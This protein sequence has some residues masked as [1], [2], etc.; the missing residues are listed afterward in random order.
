[1]QQQIGGVVKSMEEKG[2][3][4][5][6]EEDYNLNEFHNLAIEI[7]KLSIS[8][9]QGELLLRGLDIARAVADF[10]NWLSEHE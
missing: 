7:S 6:M 8:L 10:G 9:F 2:K 1:M 4:L 3:E 5:C